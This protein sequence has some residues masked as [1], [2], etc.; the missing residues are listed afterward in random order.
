MAFRNIQVDI[1]QFVRIMV[2]AEKNPHGKILLDT[3]KDIWQD[4]D[5]TL[6]KTAETNMQHYAEMMMQTQVALDGVTRPIADAIM[7]M[8]GEVVTQLRAGMAYIE[9]D[10]VLQ[11]YAFEIQGLEQLID[12]ICT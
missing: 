4:I 9:Q 5:T 2:E 12:E 1:W 11:D 10:K 8:A 3:Y 6:T 7:K